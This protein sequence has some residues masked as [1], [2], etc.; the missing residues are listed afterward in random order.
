MALRGKGMVSIGI[1]RSHTRRTG[2]SGSHGPR[3]DATALG[4]SG[5]AAN[6]EDAV[7]EQGGKR[8]ES[9]MFVVHAV[10]V[11]SARREP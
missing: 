7:G 10:H 6:V 4:A 9:S 1:L 5:A 2:S 11:S 8:R 3:R